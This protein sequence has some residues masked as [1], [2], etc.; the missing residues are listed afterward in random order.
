MTADRPEVDRQELA[1]EHHRDACL[2]NHDEQDCV[3][4]QLAA[5]VRDL[6]GQVAAERKLTAN[7]AWS[8]ADLQG[9]LAAADRATIYQVTLLREAEGKL[10][11]RDAEI[12]RL[13]GDG[14][15]VEIGGQRM[16]QAQF[17]AA[18]YPLLPHYE[19]GDVDDA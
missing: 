19:P 12:E 1:A 6:Q 16:T 15:W 17:D 9:K 2:D 4:I 8:L 10:A 13:R 11:E 5:A 7:Y 3:A 18:R 14:P